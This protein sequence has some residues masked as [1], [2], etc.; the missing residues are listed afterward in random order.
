MRTK[1]RLVHGRKTK[2][3]VDLQP[4]AQ[5]SEVCFVSLCCVTT[6][7]KGH[8][9]MKNREHQEAILS[10]CFHFAWIFN[11]FVGD[12]KSGVTSVRIPPGHFAE[13]FVVF[14][15]SLLLACQFSYK[16]TPKPPKKLS[17]CYH[18]V[19]HLLNFRKWRLHSVCSKESLSLRYYVLSDCPHFW[20]TPSGL[21]VFKFLSNIWR[22][23]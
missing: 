11:T 3:S 22:K 10:C 7:W 14:C 23:Q 19:F 6:V 5:M 15:C 12:Q 21:C 16:K 8:C 17:N 18:L 2:D 13:A 20:Q 9:N 1:C 4:Y